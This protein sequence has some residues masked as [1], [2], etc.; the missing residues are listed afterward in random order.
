MDTIIYPSTSDLIAISDANETLPIADV[1]TATYRD[2]DRLFFDP[3]G[4]M[5]G[6]VCKSKTVESVLAT[7]VDITFGR[8]GMVKELSPVVI[9]DVRINNALRSHVEMVS[10]FQNSGFSALYEQYNSFDESQ[11]QSVVYTAD[12]A[13]YVFFDKIHN[14]E[15]AMRINANGDLFKVVSPGFGAIVGN[16]Q[17]MCDVIYGSFFY[18]VYSDPADLLYARTIGIRNTRRS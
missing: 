9:K 2:G 14:M 8:G 3:H 15:L 17:R 5:H 7:G 18:V 1:G 16:P 13:D 10:V 4:Y 11:L 6:L 12:D